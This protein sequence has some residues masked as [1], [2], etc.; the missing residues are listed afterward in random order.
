M[1]INTTWPPP[2]ASPLQLSPRVV[3]LLA[4]N[5]GPWTYEGTNTWI[6]G[7][8][9]GEQCVVF[10]P[11]SFDPT[12]LGLIVSEAAQRGWT[13]SAVMITHNHPDHI[14]GTSELAQ[15]CGC[16]VW[17]LDAV[18][19]CRPLHVGTR[20]DF[21]GL[22]IEVMHLPGHTEDS[23]AFFLPAEHA[24]VSGDTVL[25]GRSC[26]V[27]GSLSDLFLSS[28]RLRDLAEDE[29]VVL[30]PGHGPVISDPLVTIDQAL[31]A[32]SGR[33]ADVRELRRQDITSV[34]AVTDRLYGQVDPARREAAEQAVSAYLEHVCGHTP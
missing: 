7:E 9:G 25:A 10:D 34:E 28:K 12:Y 14:K 13:V 5:A 30:L 16:E 15:L 4:P 11:G 8:P 22:E 20:L 29:H 18:P 3:H 1:T 33:L 32:R 24:V 21:D 19:D 17:A 31:A 6:V 27:F 26:A 2:V 23:T